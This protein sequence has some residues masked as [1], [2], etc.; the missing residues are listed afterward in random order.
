MDLLGI[1]PRMRRHVAPRNP[2]NRMY[3]GKVDLIRP[4]V[5]LDDVVA[6]ESADRRYRE[7]TD[8]YDAEMAV[9]HASP[10]R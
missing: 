9:A 2:M 4:R 8:I 10:A 5:T 7:M 6:M 3:C 1:T